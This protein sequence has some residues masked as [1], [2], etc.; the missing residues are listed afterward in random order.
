MLICGSIALIT[1]N[2]VFV[3]VIA[4][5]RGREGIWDKTRMVLFLLVLGIVASAWASLTIAQYAA[6]LV[7]PGSAWR[8]VSAVLMAGLDLL[9]YGVLRRTLG[10]GTGRV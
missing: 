8:L 10:T 9:L 7:G 3:Y 5:I 6:K 4:R 2:L 1:L